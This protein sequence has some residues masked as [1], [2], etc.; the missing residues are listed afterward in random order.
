MKDL[1]YHNYSSI[2]VLRERERE[3]EREIVLWN[4]EMESWK[5][6]KEKKI[7]EREKEI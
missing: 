1:L 7:D 3:R 6:R 2:L 4:N 5:Q